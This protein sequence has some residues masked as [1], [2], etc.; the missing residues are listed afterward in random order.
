MFSSGVFLLGGNHPIKFRRNTGG[1]TPTTRG[2][3]DGG[4]ADRHRPSG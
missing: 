2:R 1:V 3:G 4:H